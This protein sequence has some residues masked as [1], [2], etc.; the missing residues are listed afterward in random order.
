M[1]RPFLIQGHLPAEGTD[2]VLTASPSVPKV[3]LQRRLIT[4][5]HL[6]Q[7]PMP[8]GSLE[9]RKASAGC[10][11]SHSLWPRR[12]NTCGGAWDGSSFSGGPA[13]LMEPG[14]A[15]PAK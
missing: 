13:R 8:Y 4:N 12:R 5:Q 3:Q 1:S 15:Q 6:P 2:E 11:K 10:A 7:F 14:H 9:C